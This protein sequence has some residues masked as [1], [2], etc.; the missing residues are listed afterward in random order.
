MHGTGWGRA[1]HGASRGACLRDPSDPGPRP[2]SAG[3]CR[4]PTCAARPECTG[5]PSLP[6]PGWEGRT[7]AGVWSLGVCGGGPSVVASGSEFGA[8]EASVTL[9]T[10]VYSFVS[11]GSLAACLL[12]PGEEVGQAASGRL[13]GDRSPP[14]PPA[15]APGREHGSSV[16]ETPRRHLIFPTSRGSITLTRLF[17]PRTPGRAGRCTSD[18]AVFPSPWFCSGAQGLP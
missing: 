4:G 5:S 10:C 17:P 16:P 2:R 3:L 14:R 15:G 1:P 8:K 18:P 6:G 7:G 13:A 12:R 9:K 11:K